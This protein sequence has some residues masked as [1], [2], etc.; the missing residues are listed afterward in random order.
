MTGPTS[1]TDQAAC[2]AL[3]Q[4][5]VG[6]VAAWSPEQWAAQLADDAVLRGDVVHYRPYRS[7]LA[8]L[9][10][11]GQVNARA[12]GDVSE[13]YR[14]TTAANATRLQ[15]LDAEW[16]ALRL[17]PETE[18]AGDWDGTITWGSW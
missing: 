6:D 2:L 3:A 5:Q 1:S 8:Y 15:D 10:R 16:T 14:D 4:R 18:S 13:Q 12:E 7:A 17:P 9:L 11:P